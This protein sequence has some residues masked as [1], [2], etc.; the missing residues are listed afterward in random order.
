[1]RRE[2]GA[3]GLL[4]M[5]LPTRELIETTAHSLVPVD[6][7]VARERNLPSVLVLCAFSLP[8]EHSGL[9]WKVTELPVPGWK[10]VP[11]SALG[12][13]LHSSPLPTWPGRGP[14]SVPTLRK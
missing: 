12:R 6:V 10:P 11:P 7:K 3:R 4:Q 9:G 2:K 14:H 5:S 1:M 13:G 8:A